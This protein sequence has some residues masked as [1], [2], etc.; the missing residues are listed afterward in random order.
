MFFKKGQPVMFESENWRR[1]RIVMYLLMQHHQ[2]SHFK[3]QRN[4]LSSTKG[5]SSTKINLWC[6]YYQLTRSIKVDPSLKYVNLDDAA[7]A[8]TDSLLTDDHDGLEISPCKFADKSRNPNPK[9]KT[10]NPWILDS[11]KLEE[12]RK[13]TNPSYGYHYRNYRS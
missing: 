12:K 7:P 8:N 9:G 13:R 11:I 10:I 4:Y 5:S 6:Q 1:F 2:D 3:V